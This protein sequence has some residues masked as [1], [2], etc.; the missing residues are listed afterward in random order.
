[1]P[2]RARET[3]LHLGLCVVREVFIH[4]YEAEVG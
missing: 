3:I 4:L 2:L 1:M